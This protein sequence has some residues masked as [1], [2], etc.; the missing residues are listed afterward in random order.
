[1]AGKKEETEVIIYQRMKEHLGRLYHRPISWVRNRGRGHTVGR[2]VISVR[3][4]L[5]LQRSG[6]SK[7]RAPLSFPPRPEHDS[8]AFLF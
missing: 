4:Q 6:A 1:M 8:F 7:D 2:A 3:A 5:R